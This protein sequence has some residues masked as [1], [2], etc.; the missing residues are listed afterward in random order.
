MKNDIDDAKAKDLYES[1]VEYYTEGKFKN[2]NDDVKAFMC[3]KESSDLGYV[4]GISALGDMYRLG[5]GCE[6]DQMEA[7]ECYL[8]AADKGDASAAYYY[9]RYRYSDH[10][11]GFVDVA[12]DVDEALKYLEM[13]AKGGFMKAETEW[14]AVLEDVHSKYEEA[15]EYNIKA[16]KK[17]CRTAMNQLMFLQAGSGGSCVRNY[18]AAIAIL[19]DQLKTETRPDSFVFEYLLEIAH[20]F[21]DRAFVREL[22]L[23]RDNLIKYGSTFKKKPELVSITL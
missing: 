21:D 19:V 2:V 18:P 9:S 12:R 15:K 11:K 16:V 23:K 20:V 6:I 3:F 8:N 22:E 10:S 7:M 13:S 14:A 4:P 17:G 1:G 5:V